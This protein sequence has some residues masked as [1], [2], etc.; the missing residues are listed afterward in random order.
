MEIVVKP[1]FGVNLG[2]TCNETL[3]DISTVK[4]QRDYRTLLRHRGPSFPELMKRPISLDVV[5]DHTVIR[6]GRIKLPP[7][8]F[9]E[10]TRAEVDEQSSAGSS[11]ELS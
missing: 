4:A 9:E 10:I 8:I 3:L 5:K 11:T 2:S 1:M 6:V 7:T